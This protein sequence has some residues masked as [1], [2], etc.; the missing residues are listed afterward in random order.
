M[1]GLRWVGVPLL[2]I[3]IVGGWI[4]RRY[5]SPF[6]DNH[7]RY[8]HLLHI[9][10]ISATTLNVSVIRDGGWKESGGEIHSNLVRATPYHEL[11]FCDCLAYKPHH[12]LLSRHLRHV[13]CILVLSTVTNRVT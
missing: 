8:V 7:G 9:H 2:D 11:G 13:E 10:H 3:R 12:P 5:H 4:H 6:L 1:R